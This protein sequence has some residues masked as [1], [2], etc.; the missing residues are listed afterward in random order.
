[1]NQ[2]I[3]CRPVS[4]IDLTHGVCKWMVGEAHYCGAPAPAGRSWCGAHAAIVYE[5]TTVR[6]RTEEWMFKGIAKEFA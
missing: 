6:G 5:P 4:L 2:T 3:V 1:M